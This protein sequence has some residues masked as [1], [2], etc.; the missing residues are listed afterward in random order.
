[1]PMPNE[2][3]GSVSDAGTR[4]RRSSLVSKLEKT[5]TFSFFSGLQAVASA[6]LWIT[7]ECGEL[8]AAAPRRP[9]LRFRPQPALPRKAGSAGLLDVGRGLQA[10]QDEA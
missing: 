4:S 5:K 3:A 8:L 9:E 2:F 1:M 7:E 10:S 6:K